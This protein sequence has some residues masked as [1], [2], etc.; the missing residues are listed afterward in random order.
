[1]KLPEAEPWKARKLLDGLNEIVPLVVQMCRI[2]VEAIYTF[3]RVAKPR[4]KF[5]NSQRLSD[6]EI[7]KLL[8]KAL[9]IAKN[10]EIRQLTSYLYQVG[11]ARVLKHKTPIFA[12]LA[13]KSGEFGT[14]STR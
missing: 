10:G 13:N 7:R 4:K 6:F 9:E 11:D 14:V 5:R 2:R 1:M 12:C 3:L 8:E